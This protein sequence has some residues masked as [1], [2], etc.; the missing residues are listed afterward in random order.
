M[1]VQ[2]KLITKLI[3]PKLK[4][5]G[6]FILKQINKQQKMYCLDGVQFYLLD[7]V[8]FP[9]QPMQLLGKI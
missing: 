7:L 2:S 5:L 4:K 6:D 1:L 3:T 8:I 9:R